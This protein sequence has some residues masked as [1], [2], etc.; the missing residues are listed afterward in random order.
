MVSSNPERTKSTSSAPLMKGF[1]FG[2]RLTGKAFRCTHQYSNMCF[3]WIF[4]PF[5]QISCEKIFLQPFKRNGHHLH[6]RTCQEWW[7]R[8]FVEDIFSCR[9]CGT[10]C[11]FSNNFG[12][13]AM[14]IFYCNYWFQCC[15]NKD[16]TSI[17]IQSALSKRL[18]S[19]RLWWCR[20]PFWSPE[21]PACL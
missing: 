3:D 21:Q 19:E 18:S 6:W 11:C 15:R 16:I 2:D 14:C 5:Y 8:P 1:L 4:C 9:R 7:R 13:Y 10:I 12:S 20:V 17:A